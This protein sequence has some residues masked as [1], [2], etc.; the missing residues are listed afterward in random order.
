MLKFIKWLFGLLLASVFLLVAAAIILPFVIDPN[1]YKEQIADLVKQQTGRDLHIQQDLRLSVFPWLGIET[2][3]VTLGNAAG[4]GERPFAQIKQLGLK[5]KLFPLLRRQIEV[6]TL[7]LEGLQLDLV[8]NTAGS[9]NWS[10]MQQHS[11]PTSQAAASTTPVN[12][13]NQA[14][15]PAAPH[16]AFSIQGI[17]IRDA[18]IHWQD[19]QAGQAYRLDH[20]DLTTYGLYPGADSPVQSRFKIHSTQPAF[21]SEV[22]IK[23]QLQIARDMQSFNLADLVINL[24]AESPLFGQSSTMPVGLSAQMALDLAQDTLSISDLHLIGPHIKADGEISVNALRATPEIQ[25]NLHLHEMHAK[26]FANLFG[27]TMETLDPTML[28]RLSADVVLQQKNGVIKLDPLNIRLDESALAGHI[29]VLDTASPTI[30][31]ALH[32]D[33]INVDHYLPPTKE[34]EGAEIKSASSGQPPHPKTASQASSTP[35][36][37]ENQT[38]NTSPTSTNTNAS[39][40]N[41]FALLA[42]LD[43]Q[44][45]LQ[46]DNLTLNQMRIQE[47]DVEAVNKA[48]VLQLQ[49]FTA[50]LYQGEFDGDITLN[51]QGK[52]P[53]I[54]ALKRLTNIQIGD[55]LTDLTGEGRILGRANLEMNVRAAGLTESD[56]R[57]NLNGNARFQVLNGAYKGINIAQLIR[58]TSTALGF[59][60]RQ[61]VSNHQQTDFSELQ[62]SAHIVNGVINNRDLTAKSPLLRIHGDGQINLPEDMINYLLTVELVGSLEGQGGK[63][64]DALTGIP[65]PVR[66]TGPMQDP[67]YRPD[68]SELFSKKTKQHAKQE[69][70][71]IKQKVQ[72]EAIKELGDI[73]GVGEALRGL[74]GR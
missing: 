49:P 20:F 26:Q 58:E 55:L 72:Q 23:A 34:P 38:P 11:P 46:I 28:T 68:L 12:Q 44:A 33:Q 43:L 7:I 1:D 30:R 41:P 37:T 36:G 74:F 48:G 45:V 52:Q 32:V 54:Q 18:S 31:A 53:K 59:D 69:V 16:V 57:K 70:E 40:P 65:V 17:Q 61:Q 13:V 9:T 47:I 50:K 64:K 29:H 73:D 25:A 27:I 56:I 22:R 4:F 51:T 67:D 42:T 10:D 62:G 39:A 6:D 5:V 19:Q 63:E 2:G 35:P 8:K 60:T 14:E 21:A 66:I 15:Q 24:V 3:Q 71:K